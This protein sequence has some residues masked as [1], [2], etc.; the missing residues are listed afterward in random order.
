MCGASSG[1]PVAD[2]A[3]TRSDGGVIAVTSLEHTA[4]VTSKHPS[5]ARLSEIADVVIDNSGTLDETR[6]QVE[7][8]WQRLTRFP[9]EVLVVGR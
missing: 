5:G 2:T 4:R 9:R 6:R 3:S 8:E 7:R 1:G